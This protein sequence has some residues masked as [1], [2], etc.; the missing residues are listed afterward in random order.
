M[1]G[2][3]LTAVPSR[4]S[5]RQGDR[6]RSA[7]SRDKGMMFLVWFRGLRKPKYT[8]WCS[9]F[10]LFDCH[11]YCNG[12]EVFSWFTPCHVDVWVEFIAFGNRGQ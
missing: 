5:D 11:R 12:V 4:Q 9:R 10:R 2:K 7:S 1:T 6:R 8:S 3:V